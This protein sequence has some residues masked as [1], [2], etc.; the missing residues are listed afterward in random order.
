MINHN[1]NEMW[2]RALYGFILLLAFS[3]SM[4]VYYFIVS[5]TTVQES[6]PW[7]ALWPGMTSLLF[8]A[9]MTGVLTLSRNEKG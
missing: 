4:L 5:G 3:T 6:S 8:G 9:G 1:E 7:W 2:A